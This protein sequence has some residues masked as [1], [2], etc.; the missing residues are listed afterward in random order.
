MPELGLEQIKSAKKRIGN[1]VQHTPCEHSI[2]L[3]RMLGADIHIKFENMQFTA[4]FKERGALNK[5]LLLQQ[6]DVVTEVIAMSA[7]NHAKA[8][9]Y[10]AIRLGIPATIVMPR[11]TPIVKVTDTEAL[12]ANV[13]LHGETL[14]EASDFAES[15]AHQENL[16]LIHPYDDL[17]VIA[18]QGT[19]ALEMIEDQPDLDVLV[20]PVGGGGLISG[21]AVAAK[22][23]KPSIQVIG[24]Q[25]ENYA[26]VHQL[27][28]GDEVVVG[29][30]TIAEGI[31]VKYPGKNTLS[32]ID[33]YVDKILL[34]SEQ[35]LE[36]AVS[37]YINIEKTVAEGAGAASLAAVIEHPEYFAGKK[38]GV[39]LSGANIDAKVLAY[40]LLRDL[41]LAGRLL[42][43]RITLD[44]RPGSLS[45]VT[46]LVG[47][48]DGNIIDVAHQR[49]FSQVA[50]RET[51]LEMSVEVRHR[52]QGEKICQA[53]KNA[54]FDAVISENN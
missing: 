44:D 22:A 41:A 51:I 7:G 53:L 10:H 20:V 45:I 36:R 6:A 24:V 33:E 49:I 25:A 40:I 50:V 32:I 3:S 52:Q 38:V 29:G 47:E 12:G 23:L 1:A 14:A 34:V 35:S 42:R 15:I 17:A 19:V 48:Q 31:A 46:A 43:L 39:V 9:A 18:G 37:L 30:A 28:S 21:M 13:I 26:A 27:R 16:T 5:L 2:T 11:F 8:V 4:V 54:G